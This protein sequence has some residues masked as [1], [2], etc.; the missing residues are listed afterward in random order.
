MPAGARRLIVK[1]MDSTYKAGRGRS[2]LKVKCEQRQEFVIGGFTEPTGSRAGFGALLIGYY[3]NGQFR[4][5]GK[6]GTGFTESLLQKLYRMLGGLNSL[7]HRSPIRRPGTRR[8]ALTG[9]L[10]SWS[11]KSGSQNGLRRVFY[12][13]RVSRV[14][15]R[16]SRPKPSDGN[17]RSNRRERGLPCRWTRS[18]GVRRRPVKRPIKGLRLTNPDRVLYPDIGLTKAG[19]VR[20]YEQIGDWM[21]PHVKGAP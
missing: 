9:S 14:S 19:L 11:L 6:V 20:Y 21:L 2:W 4:Y 10:R 16:T 8:K 1:R 13:R 7:I 17:A 12:G 5:A 18:T 15:G 3:E